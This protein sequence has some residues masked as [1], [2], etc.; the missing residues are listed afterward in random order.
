MSLGE[1]DRDMMANTSS[2]SPRSRFEPQNSGITP[3]HLII[4]GFI[5]QFKILL[6]LY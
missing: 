2:G 1:R 5:K 6:C 3:L 4:Y